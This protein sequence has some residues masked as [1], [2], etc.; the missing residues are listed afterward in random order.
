[1]YYMARM[2]ARKKGKSGS[3]KPTS[4]EVP[5]WVKQKPKEVEQLVVELKKKDYPSSKIGLTLRD[6]HGI[7]SIQAITGKK[8]GR[9]I[10]ENELTNKFPDELM[11]LMK[12]S[13]RLHKHLEKNKHD[14]H[15]KRSIQ[16]IESKIL[17]LVKYYR[18]TNKLPEKW[19]YSYERAKLLVE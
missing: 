16:L 11:N 18:K 13:V 10:K 1:M 19:T 8:V 9:I 6:T 14:V 4:K 15:N 3:T 7:P 12:K 5:K 2:H 17:R